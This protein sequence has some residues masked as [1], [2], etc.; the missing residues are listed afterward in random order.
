M[1][2]IRSN[3]F[4]SWQRHFNRRTLLKSTAVAGIGWLTPFAKRLARGDE[5][6]KIKEP[7]RSMIVLWLQGGPSQL[8]TCDPHPGESIGGDT[9]A[10]KTAAKDI[11]LADGL[12]LLA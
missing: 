9:K 8:E 7:A 11:Q 5:Q 4:C 12:P 3:L 10:I 2:E 6:A 1:N